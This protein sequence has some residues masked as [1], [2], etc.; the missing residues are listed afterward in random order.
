M[1]LRIINSFE[2]YLMSHIYENV[3]ITLRILFWLDSNDNRYDTVWLDC[4]EKKLDVVSTGFN[5]YDNCSDYSV[6]CYDCLG[7][8]S[9]VWIRAHPMSSIYHHQSKHQLVDG[10][11][12]LDI[13]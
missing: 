7:N 6:W 2:Q 9:C 1:L 11:S 5:N 4:E 13:Y 3:L 8:E 10:T 12:H